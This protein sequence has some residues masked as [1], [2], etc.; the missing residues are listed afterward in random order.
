MKRWCSRLPPRA[1]APARRAGYVCQSYAQAQQ[2]VAEGFRFLWFGN[3]SVFVST[4]MQNLRGE[5][6]TLG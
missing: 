3:D 1:S 5:I 4:G 2:R 6:E